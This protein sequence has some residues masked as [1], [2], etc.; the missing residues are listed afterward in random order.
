M[1][2]AE[3][4]KELMQDEGLSRR[5]AIAD[6]DHLGWD[7]DSGDVAGERREEARQQALEERAEREEP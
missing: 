4:I 3:R 5:A 7:A 1:T 2:R 6:V